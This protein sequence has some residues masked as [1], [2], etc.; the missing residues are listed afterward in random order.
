MTAAAMVMLALIGCPD[1]GR[2]VSRRAVSCPGCG[3]PGG[4]IAERARELEKRKEPD[5]FAVAHTGDGEYRALPVRMGGEGYLVL[6][7]EV[8]FGLEKLWFT[9]ASKEGTVGYEAPE[10]ALEVPLARF[11]IGETNFVFAA[12]GTNVATRLAEGGASPARAGGWLGVRPAVFKRHGET[13]RK[14][15][16]GE[17]ARLPKDAHPMYLK[18]EKR[19]K[20]KGSAR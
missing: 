10:V 14:I 4:A 6:P 1:C 16:A 11:R 9:M 13:L 5:A 15:E 12:E 8:S 17:E 2:E 3:C 19:L 20:A 7:L 18:L